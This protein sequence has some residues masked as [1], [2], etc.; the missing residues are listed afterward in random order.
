VLPST[1]SRRRGRR[2]PWA[3]DRVATFPG[4]CQAHKVSTLTATSAHSAA[5]VWGGKQSGCTCGH[6]VA[7]MSGTLLAAQ[8]HRGSSFRPQ[9]EGQQITRY[10]EGVTKW[11]ALTGRGGVGAPASQTTHKHM[12]CVMLA[13]CLHFLSPCLHIGCSLR[14]ILALC[15]A[16]SRDTFAASANPFLLHA[17]IFLRHVY[18]FLLHA[19]IFLFFFYFFLILAIPRLRFFIP[20]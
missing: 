3:E 10:S 16:L 19:C 12:F 15:T 5:A 18:I 4:P 17:Y 8:C 11:T 6:Q 14:L 20:C 7:H 2:T 9:P 1:L 13:C